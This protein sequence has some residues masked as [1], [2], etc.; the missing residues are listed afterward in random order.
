MD[1]DPVWQLG[2]SSAVE[3][4]VLGG[5]HPLL[6]C[7]SIASSV[8]LSRTRC[9]RFSRALFTHLLV[10][11]MDNLSLVILLDFSDGNGFPNL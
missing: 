7:E 4:L 2:R 5:V 11:S 1:I 8:H 3:F 9:A 6:R 10:R